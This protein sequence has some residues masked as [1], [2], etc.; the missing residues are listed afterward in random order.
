MF[1]AAQAAKKQRLDQPALA[2]AATGNVAVRRGAGEARGAAG[3]EGGAEASDSE[4]SEGE[5]EGEGEEEE[6]GLGASS[7]SDREDEEGG[8]AAAAGS[9]GVS[10][11]RGKRQQQRAQ[12]VLRPEENTKG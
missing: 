10:G 1:C 3:R 7:G 12:F 6:E 9:D 4:G 2:T 5:G 11:G 8:A